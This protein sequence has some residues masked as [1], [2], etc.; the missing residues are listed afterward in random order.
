MVTTCNRKLGNGVLK[1]LVTRIFYFLFL[2][3]YVW[4]WL[5]TDR[6]WITVMKSI[7]KSYATLMKNWLQDEK[8]LKLTLWQIRE[9]QSGHIHLYRPTVGFVSADICAWIPL[10]PIGGEIPMISDS[11]SGSN[12]V[13][14]VEEVLGVLLIWIDVCLCC[15]HCFHLLLSLGSW[16]QQWSRFIFAV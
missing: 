15:K 1:T 13:R 2:H 8:C 12:L 10:V 3:P 7:L 6:L 14:G 11:F 9:V 16:R 4:Y 5:S